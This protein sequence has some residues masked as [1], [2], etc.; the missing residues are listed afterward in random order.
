M[1][2]LRKPPTLREKK[3]KLPKVE[4]RITTAFLSHT[5]AKWSR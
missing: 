4:R 1:Q 3:M 5:S 2:K